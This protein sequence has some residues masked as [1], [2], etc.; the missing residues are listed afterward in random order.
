MS[1]RSH[2]FNC[3]TV[4][5]ETIKTISDK[6]QF[7]DIFKQYFAARDVYLRTKSGDMT[8][9]FLGYHDG[10]VA[11]RIPRVKNVPDSI[12][13]FTRH[14][15]DTIYASLKV[16]ENNED[17]FIFMPLKFQIISD[18]RKEDRL[19]IGV[20]ENKNII[21]I[22][23]IISESMLKNSLDVNE[24][25]MRLVRDMIVQELKGKFERIRIVFINETS[26]DVRMKH[27]LKVWTPLYIKDMSKPDLSKGNQD[28]NFYVNE[29]H[30]KDYKLAGQEEF[31]SEVS[32]PIIY[33]SILPYGYIQVNNTKPMNDNHL[34]VIK[35]IAVSVNESLIRERIF[36]PIQEKFIVPNISKKGLAVVFKER[37][38]L[39]YFMKDS[40]V[41]IDMMLPDARKVTMG[42]LVSNTIF[43]ESG[44]IKVGLEITNIDAIS[45]VNFE[46]FLDSM[47]QETR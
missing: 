25:K 24:K 19:E 5:A 47:K 27:F 22:S 8:I 20:A 3:G 34:T 17:T 15:V 35:R 30:T 39:R 10:N 46:E 41:V 14:K 1:I 9:Q 7:E 4:M 28:F 43:N 42:V 21:Y 31:I 45:E 26:I 38:Q 6:S 44:V 37:K 29:I 16:L 36:T 2:A 13:I 11:F 33:K 23:N 12:L 40:H 32:V 18:E